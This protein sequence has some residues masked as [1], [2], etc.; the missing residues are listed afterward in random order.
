MQLVLKIIIGVLG[1][2]NFGKLYSLNI[3]IDYNSSMHRNFVDVDPRSDIPKI[4]DKANDISELIDQ[5]SYDDYIIVKI[6]IE[7]T[8]FPLIEHLIRQG[9]IHKVDHLT[10]EFHDKDFAGKPIRFQEKVGFYRTLMNIYGIKHSKWFLAH[11]AHR[12]HDF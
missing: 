2:L 10:V 8:E 1:T 6:D 4:I 5:Y 7:G 9:T 11:G 3:F 12:N